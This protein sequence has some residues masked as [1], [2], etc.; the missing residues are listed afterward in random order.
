MKKAIV[1]FGCDRP[2]M[3]VESFKSIMRCKEYSSYEWHCYIDGQGKAQRAFYQEDFPDIRF[4]VREQRIGLNANILL[5]FKDLF[6][7]YHYDYLLYVEDDVILS[8]DCIR[9]MEYSTRNFKTKDIFTI[10]A[11]SRMVTNGNG[12]I[13][14]AKQFDWYHPWGVLIDRDDYALIEPH[15]VAYVAHPIKYMN[16]VLQDTIKNAR[17]DYYE[18][19]Y[20]DGLCMN[21]TQDC[22]LNAL[23]AVNN[24]RQLIPVCSRAQNIGF[25]GTHQP[26]EYKGENLSDTEIHLKSVHATT[27]F[28]PHYDWDSIELVDGIEH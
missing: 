12:D 27:T 28:N 10:G 4:N 9:Y 21:I 7:F 8:D 19:E 2:E 6:E 5:A 1:S 11:F 26:G 24:K 23:R 25:Y 14:K 20:K 15:I 3:M 22:L 16:E 13:N 17:P 18:R